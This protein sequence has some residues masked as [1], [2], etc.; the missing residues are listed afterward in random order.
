M[1]LAAMDLAVGIGVA[2][3]FVVGILALIYLYFKRL[4]IIVKLIAL[5]FQWLLRRGPFKSNPN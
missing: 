5:P 2:S 3:I 4:W 1:P